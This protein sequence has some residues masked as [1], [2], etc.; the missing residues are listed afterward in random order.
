MID[1]VKGQGRSGSVPHGLLRGVPYFAALPGNVIDA[2]AQ[3][4]VERRV[5]RGQIIF[6]E[7]EPCAGLYI[8]GEGTVK[9]YKLSPQGREQ[10]VH[11]LEAG[12]T[13]N[14]VAVLDGGPNPASAAAN[15]D[16][17][18]WV[19]ARPDIERLAQAYPALAWA[20][21]ESI[22]R[23]TRHL[24]AMVED[25]SLRSVRA[26]L[27]KLLLAEAERS[28][29]R[30]EIRREQMVTQTEMAARLGTVREMVGRALRELVDDGLITQD[31]QR[32]VIADRER[33]R[34]IADGW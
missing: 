4:A 5:A 26:R 1:R 33:L 32:I 11:Q 18:L 13:F 14:D 25:L 24:L 30:G 22:A 10:I 20:L 3:V 27:A 19:I 7:G 8:V 31:R 9:I 28:A 15:S 12:S 16:A 6:L 17:T 23:R 21:I 29:R 34:A 2:L